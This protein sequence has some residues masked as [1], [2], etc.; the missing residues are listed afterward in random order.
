MNELRVI[1]VRVE[2]PVT[3]FRYPHFLI[4]RQPTHD[5]PPPSTIYGHIASA[6]GELPDPTSFRFGYHFTFRSRGS[7]LE[8]QHIISAGGAKFSAGGRRYA[9][10]VQA[11][12]Q[13]HVRDFLFGARLTLYVT[14]PEWASAFREPAFC[15][16]LGR[17]Q[18]LASVTAVD[19]LDLEE[20][21]GAYLEHTILPFSYRPHIGIGSTVLLPRYIG[22]PP[23]RNAHFERFIALRERIFAGEFESPSALPQRFRT[24]GEAE[25]S[26]WVDPDT[27]AVRGVHRAVVLHQCV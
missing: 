16:I 19:E 25:T 27:T 3:S 17:S 24:L 18:D 10:S 6:L 21:T 14:R 1:R 8:H 20:K 13:P 7:D 22:P 12:I 26:W 4:G 5:V 11:V 9:T 2:A 15:V 23:E